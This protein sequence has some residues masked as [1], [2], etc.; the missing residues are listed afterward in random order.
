MFIKN[1]KLENIGVFKGKREFNF[2]KG[3]N[4]I[5]GENGHGKSTLLEVISLL[6]INEYNGNL[7]SLINNSCDNANAEL[8]FD[9]N[10][11]SYR[12]TIELSKKKSTTS[13]K[14]LYENN[15][16]V[17]NGEEVEKY[18]NNI[19]PKELVNHSLFV[20]Q[21]GDKVTSVSDSDRRE[22]LAQLCELDYTRKIKE[23]IDPQIDFL[24]CE[25]NTKEKEE[26]ALENKSYNFGQ[27]KTIENIWNEENQS[28]LVSLERKQ[29]EYEKNLEL[30]KRISDLNYKCHNLHDDLK[31]KQLEYNVDKLSEENSSQLKKLECEHK[32]NLFNLEE[33]YLNTNNSMDKQ[34]SDIQNEIKNIENQLSNIKLVKLVKFNED[35]LNEKKKQYTSLNSEHKYLL[36][37]IEKL[38]YN[39]NIINEGKCPYRR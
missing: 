31:R 12:N 39:L 16:L 3:S 1:L 32:T 23:I 30:K 7:E 2:T 29:K 36:D 17:A 26:Y 9:H 38:Q 27:E 14:E 8:E 15:E 4:L 25:I 10:N 35:E 6:L 33:N 18:L 24:K 28:E 5:L 13:K 22:I 11:K 19:L 37:E 34:I 21:K 20:K